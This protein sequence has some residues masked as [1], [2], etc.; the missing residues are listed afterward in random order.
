MSVV[1]PSQDAHCSP[2]GDS[3]AAV[4]ANAAASV[5]VVA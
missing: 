4:L 1:G 2:V 3:A 5:G